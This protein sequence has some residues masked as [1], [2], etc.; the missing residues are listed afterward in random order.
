MKQLRHFIKHD[1]YGKN[2]TRADIDKMAAEDSEYDDYDADD[3]GKTYLT[4]K[5][6]VKQEKYTRLWKQAKE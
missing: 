6:K 5:G 3:E 2:Y 1:C 4:A